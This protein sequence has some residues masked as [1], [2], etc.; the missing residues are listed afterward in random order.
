MKFCI[1]GLGF[2][3][4]NLALSLTR[5]GAEVIAVD[6][7]E[8]MVLPLKDVVGYAATVDCSDRH[9]LSQL[10]LHD[11][12]AV[13]V[14]IGEDFEGSLLTIAHLQELGL[15][16]LYCRAINRVHERL[17]GL[18]KIEHIISPEALAANRLARS[19]LFTGVRNSFEL[20]HGYDI[21]E[22]DVP[23]SL[24]G[25]SLK[26]SNLRGSFSLNLVT[27][28]ARSR[29]EETPPVGSA[30]SSATGIYQGVIPPDRV[31]CAEDILVLFGSE[32]DIKRFL[33]RHS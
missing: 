29:G 4:R 30:D 32:R 15:R 33:E 18:L 24:V 1:I 14:A 25:H 31:F 2:F 9:A 3:G 10:P 8:E 26:E 20:G 13:I 28:K 7:S 11:M 12:D 16:R 22:V 23:R 19:L 17:L 21:V 27:I 5:L 6:R